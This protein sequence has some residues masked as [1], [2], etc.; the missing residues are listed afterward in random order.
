MFIAAFLGAVGW[1]LLYGPLF[2]TQ[3]YYADSENCRQG[4][5]IATKLR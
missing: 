3:T 1:G 5:V 4:N 2:P